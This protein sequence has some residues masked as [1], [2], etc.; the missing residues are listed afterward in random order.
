MSEKKS[1]YGVVYIKQLQ[2]EMI[3]QEEARREEVKRL[4]EEK[5]QR[6]LGRI[7]ITG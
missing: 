3:L 2:K 6:Y 7:L 1:R 4:E 5:R